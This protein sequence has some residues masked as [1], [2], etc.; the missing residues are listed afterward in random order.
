MISC[1]PN[2]TL[3]FVLS[4]PD[5]PWAW[6]DISENPG[7]TFEDIIAHPELRWYNWS[8]LSNNFTKS[9]QEFHIQHVRRHLAAFRIQQHWHRIRM[10]PRHPVCQRRLELEY[11]SLVAGYHQDQ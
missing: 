3:D 2:L 1:N 6:N 5:K 10:D 7:I 9:R 8:I 4:N 11:D